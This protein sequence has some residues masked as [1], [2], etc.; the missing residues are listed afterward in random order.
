MLNNLELWTAFA[1]ELSD[2]LFPLAVYGVTVLAV[3]WLH[4]AIHRPF[5][6]SENDRCQI[7]IDEE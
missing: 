6:V 5:L 3:S 1:E 7:R 2:L 4:V